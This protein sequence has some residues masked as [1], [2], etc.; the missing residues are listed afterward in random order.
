[1]VHHCPKRPNVPKKPVILRRGA[2]KNRNV[3]QVAT[4][5]F[6]DTVLIDYANKS[7]LQKLMIAVFT[8]NIE[9]LC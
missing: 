5:T 1:M 3:P 2:D 4:G 7:H 9:A 6:W 8:T